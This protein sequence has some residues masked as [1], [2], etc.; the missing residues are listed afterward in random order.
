ML[1]MKKNSLYIVLALFAGLLMGFLFF[2][3]RD[4]EPAVK[5]HEQTLETAERSKKWTCSMHPQIILEEPGTCPICGMALIPI[6]TDANGLTAQQFK[7]TKNAEAL[8]N[9]KTTTISGSKGADRSLNLSGTIQVN[10]D[11][12]AILPA[13]FN[14]RIE[15]LFVTSVGQKV[16]HGQRVATI[17]SP[18]LI[19]AQQELITAY[20]L[21]AEQPQLYAAVRQKFKNWMIDGAQLDEVEQTGQV[22]TQFNIYTHVS[23]TVSEINVNEGDHIMDGKP[24]FKV[25]NL[26][27]VWAEFDAYENQISRI[28]IGQKIEIATKAYP[29]DII[30]G[31]VSF[32]D[33]ILNANTRT[34]KIRVVLKNAN[35]RFKP[36]MFVEGKIKDIDLTESSK[37]TIPS[38]AVMWTGKRSVVYLK[39]NEQTPVFEMREIVLGNK[40]GENYEV[41][42]G[43]AVGDIIVTN[44]TFTV[45]AAAQLQG[46]A[47]MMNQDYE[48]LKD[49]LTITNQLEQ[50]K[51]IAVS[52]VFQKEIESVFDAYIDLKDALV[53]DDFNL[54]NS[55]GKNVMN[56]IKKVDETLIANHENAKQRFNETKV[57]LK[58][59][60][61]LM[62]KSESIK[63][64]RMYFSDISESIKKIVEV[65]GIHKKV[66]VQFCPMANNNT[67]GY[68]LSL[69]QTI[70]NPYFGSEMLGCG[71]NDKTIE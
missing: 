13:H 65:F 18:E 15:N 29:N 3:T 61:E 59:N 40:L 34:V 38:S 6:E 19:S 8:A 25:N 63:N 16:S 67:G 7:L 47:S 33:P 14:G 36:G 51:R 22:I 60:L 52:K 62:V 23:G 2:G 50:D 43:L 46:K 48:S 55:E 24:I 44:G 5:T 57:V 58:H 68:W 1:Q 66:Y 4:P 35:Q 28:Q 30:V 69:E 56:S 45:D 42:S 10:A 20:K 49:Q 27:T 70:R 21:K 41:L 12:T 17:Y 37:I 11:E 39:V 54:A 32:I 9:I 53:N 26:N 64:Q 71:E 31:K